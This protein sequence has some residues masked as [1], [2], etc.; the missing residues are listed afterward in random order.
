[1]N[2]HQ[3]IQLGFDEELTK[4]AAQKHPDDL[5]MAANFMLDLAATTH[6]K[7]KFIDFRPSSN[8]KDDEIQITPYFFENYIKYWG[9]KIWDGIKFCS[10]KIWKGMKWIWENADSSPLGFV[11][12][13][14]YLIKYLRSNDPKQKQQYKDKSLY[15]LGKAVNWLFITTGVIVGGILLPGVGAPIG[16]GIGGIIATTFEALCGLFVNDKN[17]KQNMQQFNLSSYFK[18]TIAG[19]LTGLAAW[20]WTW[21]CT[22]RC[23]PDGLIGMLCKLIFGKIYLLDKYCQHCVMRTLLGK[24]PLSWCQYIWSSIGINAAWMAGATIVLGGIDWVI[25]KI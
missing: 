19:V 20:L 17:I 5:Q 14:Y 18:N 6:D 13:I 2:Y 4:A 11:K 22:I 7:H 1:M 10:K 23:R 24:L 21:I 25:Q 3:L 8:L 9:N 12:A 16:G 15:S